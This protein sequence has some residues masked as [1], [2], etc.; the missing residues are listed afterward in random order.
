MFIKVLHPVL[1]LGQPHLWQGYMEQ[2]HDPKYADCI[3][4]TAHSQPPVQGGA[5]HCQ[6]SSCMY[7]YVLQV[8]SIIQASRQT[9]GQLPVQQLQHHTQGQHGA[10]VAEVRARW[11]E[12]PMP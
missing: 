6:L 2:Q 10:A 8:A 7:K 11:H 1:A 4:L 5:P 12:L 9:E 3:V